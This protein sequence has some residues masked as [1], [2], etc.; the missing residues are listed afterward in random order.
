V[1]TSR[2]IEMLAQGSGS[3]PRR[4]VPVRLGLALA[5]GLA[6]SATISWLALGLNPDL[7]TM[8]AALT[9]K[10]G[11]VAS[12]TA[13]AAWLTARLARPGAAWGK[14]L[15]SVILLFG[16]MCLLACIDW[17]QADQ[18]ERA[19]LLFG[20]SWTTCP[21][22]VA[23]LAGP[24]LLLGFLAVRGLAPTRLRLAGAAIG[25]MAGGLGAFGYALYCP[26]LSPL[27]VVTWYSLGMLVPAAIGAVLGPRTLRW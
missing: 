12:L 20:Q 2:L 18:T 8:G 4:V 21:W 3:A 27:F 7:A 26:E 1:K 6:M 25:L 23:A 10:L 5:L 17:N 14:A 19:A 13:G 24:A 15:T 16:A 9:L 11:Y 22:R